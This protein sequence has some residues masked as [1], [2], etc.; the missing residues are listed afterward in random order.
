MPLLSHLTAKVYRMDPQNITMTPQSSFVLNDI[1]L[2]L[3]FIIQPHTHGL[4]M[5]LHPL[6]SFRC[7]SLPSIGLYHHR[8]PY[9]IS[10]SSSLPSYDPPSNFLTPP[11]PPASTLLT[12]HPSVENSITAALLYT[13]SHPLVARLS[14]FISIHQ[15]RLHYISATLALTCKLR[16][17]FFSQYSI[18]IF[19][20]TSS[21]STL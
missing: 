4:H 6:A 20:N 21:Y 5:P 18:Q 12:S 2:S 15:K 19:N 16:I 1:T 13:G 8:I 7:P 11:P 3:S 14:A 9:F 17:S 10:S